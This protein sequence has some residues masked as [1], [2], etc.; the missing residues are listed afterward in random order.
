MRLK[1]RAER[2][3]NKMKIDLSKVPPSPGCYLYKNSQGQIIYIGKAKDLKKRV[4][5][6]FN[7]Q[8]KDPKTQALVENIDSVEFIVTNTEVEA[9]ILENNLIKKHNPKYNIDLRD[10]KR[11]AYIKITDEE[12]PRLLI[13][14]KKETDEE[15]FGPF[16]SGE[17][18]DYILQTLI[19]IQVYCYTL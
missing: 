2:T 5:Q 8:E 10:S 9:L 19:L 18:R 15:Y 4:S 1:I 14:R 6:Y 12:F 7:S 11:Y 13:A 16:T 17:K 3:I